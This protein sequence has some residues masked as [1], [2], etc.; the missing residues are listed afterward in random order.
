MK[1]NAASKFFLT[2]LAFLAIV[3]VGFLLYRFFTPSSTREIEVFTRT[4]DQRKISCVTPPPEDI[5]KD[6][7]LKWI[8]P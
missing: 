1:A 4:T 3:G 2:V 7:N 8:W 5:P 6:V